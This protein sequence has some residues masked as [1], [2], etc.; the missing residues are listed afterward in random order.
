ME[1]KIC[2]IKTSRPYFK[3]KEQVLFLERDEKF[4]N[5]WTMIR[6]RKV[7]KKA[8]LE[9][10]Q[11]MLSLRQIAK[12]A[13]PES[14][15]HKESEEFASSLCLRYLNSNFSKGIGRRI[16]AFENPKTVYYGFR[17]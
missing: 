6:V 16:N 17:Q 15:G 1:T 11:R 12:Q 7:L 3:G 13:F 14:V 9:K 10:P 4:W 5:F 2:P 8:K